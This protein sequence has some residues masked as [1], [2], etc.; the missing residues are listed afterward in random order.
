MNC[1]RDGSHHSSSERITPMRRSCPWS[2]GVAVM[3]DEQFDVPVTIESER[4][5]RPL[6]VT[7]TVQAASLLVDNWPDE[8]RGPKYRAALKA[9]MDAMEQ[10]R[11]VGSARR[12]FTAAA[13]EAHVF[14]RE[15]R[16]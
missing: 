13:K 11:A 12:A 16:H 9:M 1:D 14:V 15:G 8:K 2:Q 4:I 3:R 10:R 7:R 5:G 6:S